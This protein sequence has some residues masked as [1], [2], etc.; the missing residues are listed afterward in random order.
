MIVCIRCVPVEAQHFQVNGQVGVYVD[1]VST[2]K[3][4]NSN[5]VVW[6]RP[7]DSAN[8]EKSRLESAQK[9]HFA[10]VQRDHTFV[11]HLLIVPVGA[12]V[13]FP[14]HDL[15]F[16]DVFSMF[17]GKRFYLGLY[18]AGGTKAVRLNRPG[19][20][21][22]FCNIHYQMSAVVI[23]LTTPYYYGVSDQGGWVHIAGVPHGRYELKVWAEGSSVE[24]LNRLS[25]VISVADDSFLGTLR[26]DTMPAV[27]I[28]HQNKF[29]HEYDPTPQDPNYGGAN[30]P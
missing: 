27:K 13:E 3:K 29:E 5:V 21:Y 25:R 8:A 18:E 17:D 10:I 28:G 24:T 26:I 20:S 7:L 1:D 11:P 19:I 15:V 22:V 2:K 14:N 23:A 30:P 4:D 16:H 6:L 12:I 9:E